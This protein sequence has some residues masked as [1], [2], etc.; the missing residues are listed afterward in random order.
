MHSYIHFCFYDDDVDEILE[1]RGG[2]WK[3]TAGVIS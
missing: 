1:T 2:L 3:A